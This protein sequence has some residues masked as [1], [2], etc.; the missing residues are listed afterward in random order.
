M[1]ENRSGD[2]ASSTCVT[3]PILT[4]YTRAGAAVKTRFYPCRHDGRCCSIH[5]ALQLL[6]GLH[7]NAASE[8]RQRRVLASPPLLPTRGAIIAALALPPGEAG[9]A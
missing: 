4:R 6:I 3:L 7:A 9:A 8:L 5:A 1:T 2:V